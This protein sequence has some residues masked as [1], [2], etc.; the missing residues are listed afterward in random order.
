MNHERFAD[1]IRRFNAEDPS[2]FEDYLTP[3]VTVQNGTLHYAGIEAMKAH[4]AKIWSGMKETIAVLRCVCDGD[5]LAAQL[6]T[7][8]EALRDDTD[9]VLGPVKQGETFDYTGVV[10]YRIEDGRFA[11][12]LVSYLDFVH[13]DTKGQRRSLGIPH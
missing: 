5:T 3:T 10:M 4:Y 2:A 8:F 7:H 13:T 6:H 12:I 1:Y 11:D 9:S